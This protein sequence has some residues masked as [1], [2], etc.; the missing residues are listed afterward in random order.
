M[1][2]IL[3]DMVVGLGIW[4]WDLMEIEWRYGGI[5]GDLMGIEWVLLSGERGW[6]INYKLEIS[7]A[8]GK[9]TD[10]NIWM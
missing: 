6:K 1:V 3:A 2:V 9:L 10:P 5:T 4:K 7:I 8:R